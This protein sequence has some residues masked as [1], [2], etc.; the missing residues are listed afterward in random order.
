MTSYP[1]IVWANFDADLSHY[2]MGSLTPNQLNH[3]IKKKN[4]RNLRLNGVFSKPVASIWICQKNNA[5]D[6]RMGVSTCHQMS[7]LSH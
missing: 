7:L 5:M 6:L 3:V 4:A 2:M 1:A